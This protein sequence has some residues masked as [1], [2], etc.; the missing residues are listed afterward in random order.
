MAKSTRAVLAV[1]FLSV[2]TISGGALA[3]ANMPAGQY[4]CQVELPGGKTEFVDVQA[5]E[6]KAAEDILEG[7]SKWS[8]P[9]GWR[10]VEC[11][12]P[13]RERFSSSKAAKAYNE[14]VR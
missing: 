10:L 1:V 14:Q 9:S 5:S 6:L 12:D 7:K 8:V 3:Q 4:V 2:S 11:I 13:V